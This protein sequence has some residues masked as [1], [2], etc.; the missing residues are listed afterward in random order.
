MLVRYETLP[1]ELFD[2]KAQEGPKTIQAMVTTLSSPPELYGKK[3]VLKTPCTLVVEYR[4]TILYLSWKLP[5]GWITLPGL[6]IVFQASRR[7]N[8]VMFFHRLGPYTLQSQFAS[9]GVQK[10][11]DS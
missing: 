10:G 6:C 9:Q 2:T 3:L 1:W 4:E 5:L 11:H 7:E 8:L